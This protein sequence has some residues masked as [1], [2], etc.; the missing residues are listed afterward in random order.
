MPDPPLAF[1]RSQPLRGHA[2][3]CHEESHQGKLCGGHMT[4]KTEDGWVHYCCDRCGIER[5]RHIATADPEARKRIRLE[6]AGLP[7]RF[8]GIDF[9]PSPENAQ[10]CEQ[11]RQWVLGF[12]ERPLPAPALWGEQGRGKTHLLTAICVRLIRERDAQVMFRSVRSL[13]RELQRF[14][15]EVQVTEAWQRAK[16]VDVLALDDLGAQRVTDWRHEQLAELID[17][18]YEADLPILVATNYQ[19]EGWGQVLDERSVSRLAGMT[20]GV[21]LRGVD[22]RVPQEATA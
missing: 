11:V 10:A 21:E 12:K 16:T 19:P 22:R 5:V 13:L 2:M 4:S 20:F 17:E 1:R 15:N 6:Q 7:E 18:R 3:I 8:V 14:G 9:D